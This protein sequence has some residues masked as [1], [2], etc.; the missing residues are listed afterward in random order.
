M[1][2]TDLFRKQKHRLSESEEKIMAEAS[3]LMQSPYSIYI[4]FTNAELPWPTVELSN[5]GK[6][7]LNQS[8]YSKYRASKNRAD[9]EKVFYAF[10]VELKKS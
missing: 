8:G 3:M 4:I 10:F 2:L 5:G 6:A 7:T 9:R 1:Y